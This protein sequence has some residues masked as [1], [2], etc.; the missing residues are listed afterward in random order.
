MPVLTPVQ[1]MI[2]VSWCPFRRSV[3]CFCGVVCAVYQAPAKPTSSPKN[4]FFA[5]GHQ[6][7]FHHRF[8]PLVPQS[9]RIASAERAT[10]AQQRFAKEHNLKLAGSRKKRI[11]AAGVLGPPSQQ[12]RESS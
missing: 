7:V 10:T 6:L 5:A 1:Q 2:G 11:Q 9:E 12:S 3:S 4:G 8:K